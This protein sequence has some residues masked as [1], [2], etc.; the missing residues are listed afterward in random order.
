M[1]AK[2][3]EWLRIYTDTNPGSG[4]AMLA[5]WNYYHWVKEQMIEN[6]PINEF[7]AALVTGN[8]SNISNPPSNYYTMLPQGHINPVRLSE[9]TAQIFLGIRTQCAQCHNHPFDRWTMD[10]YY[11]FQSFFMG[12]RRKH[13]AEAREYFTFVDIDAE[14]AKHPIDDRPMAHKF[15][16]GPEADVED[17]D[18]RKVLAQWMTGPKN[19]L[20]REN[21]ANRIWDHLFGRGIV[22]PVDDVR[23][24][25]PPSNAPLLLELGRRLGEVYNYD[26][27]KL[28][29]DICL[30]RTYQLS[31]TA[32]EA[33]KMDEMFFSHARLRRLRAD[34]LFDSLAQALEY[35]HMFRRSSAERA[36][37]MFEG[38][39]R[40]NF[41]QYFFKTFGHARRESVCACEDRK[42]ATLS[43]T[44]H[45]I[46]G[47]TIDKTFT[48]N[49]QL[50]PRLMKEHPDDP[51]S[52]VRKLYI[53]SLTR[54]PSEKELESML[55]MHPESKDYKTRMYYFNNIAWALVNSSEFLFNH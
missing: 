29:R 20:F 36:L 6:T 51:E 22:D 41:N 39:R 52:I 55:A 14:P 45:L 33:N 42:E 47:Q 8:G 32:T 13:G 7:A 4:T 28:V 11:A 46:N 24:S 26:Q 2:W 9:D 43:Q 17:K 5:G 25:T 27:K 40:D 21:I 35:K 44:L 48:R 37:V 34:V 12:V 30:S 16:G 49:P 53:R 38:G 18:P 23:I 10:D 3:G 50:I 15:L 54:Q 1:A 19:R 31:A